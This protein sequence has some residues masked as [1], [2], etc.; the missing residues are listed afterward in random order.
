MCFFCLDSESKRAIYLSC[1]RNIA[2][3][4]LV[5]ALCAFPLSARTWTSSDGVKTFE[6]SFKGYDAATQTVSVMR[7]HKKLSFTMDKLSEADRKWVEVEA[8]RLAE[9]EVLA[10]APSVDEQLEQ[11]E[12][13]KNLGSGVLERLDGKRFAKAELEKAPEYYLLYF[14]ASW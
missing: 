13:G 1:M 2:F 6:G 11:Q 14:S 9:L 8:A 12:V 4:S 10:N 5:L 7:G 3:G